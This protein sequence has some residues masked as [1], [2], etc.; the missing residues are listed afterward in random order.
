MVGVAR[1]YIVLCR[2]ERLQRHREAARSFARLAIERAYEAESPNWVA[3]TL[4]HVCAI[5]DNVDEAET[6]GQQALSIFRDL[7]S[8][9]GQANV[10][11]VL[12]EA[13]AR[14]GA[15]VEA[16]RRYRESLDLMRLLD[17]RWSTV[18]IIIDTAALA[19][20]RGWHEAA[21]I[22]LAAGTS[23]ATT[24]GYTQVD[25]PAS[26]ARLTDEQLRR[27]LDAA[28]F[29][30]ATERG[31][32]LSADEA[33]ALVRSVLETIVTGGAMP[34]SFSPLV[35]T[36]ETHSA[37]ISLTRR[38]R[39]ILELLGQHL[40]DAQIAAQLFLS[41]RTASNHVSRILAKLGVANRR[42]AVAF[43]ARHALVERSAPSSRGN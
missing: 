13:A 19:A 3:W 9:F 17:E 16:A 35:L 39:E 43:A 40:T 25:H 31:A 32:A 11:R 37:R 2:A 1:A 28:R 29:A 14:R 7:G 10:L 30:R 22:L 4:V 41:P 24:V 12:A 15:D 8:E 38:E 23:W 36:P 5:T 26:L 33:V 21:G 34:A 42:E 27:K 18:D 20:H 6:A